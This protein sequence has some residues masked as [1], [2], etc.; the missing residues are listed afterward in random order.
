[1]AGVG[2]TDA[3]SDVVVTSVVE[4][5]EEKSRDADVTTVVGSMDSKVGSR[6][7]EVGSMSSVKF[8]NVSD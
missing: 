7:T 2:D 4:L 8:E 1:M 3:R 5:T 6:D